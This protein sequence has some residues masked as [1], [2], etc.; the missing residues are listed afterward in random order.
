MVF[1]IIDTI[2]PLYKKLSTL[3]RVLNFTILKHFYFTATTTLS[4]LPVNRVSAGP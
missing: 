1:Q 4:M 2:N 3:K